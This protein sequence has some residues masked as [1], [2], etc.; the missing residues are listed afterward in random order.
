M[1]SIY[2]S[3]T[4]SPPSLGGTWELI[5]DGYFLMSTTGVSGE[6]GGSESHSHQTADHTLT[7]YEMPS[8]NHTF[9]GPN[10]I[11]G[12]PDGQKDSDGSSTSSGY[13]YWRGMPLTDYKST[14]SDSQPG[15]LNTGNNA[16][17]NHGDTWPT[18]HIPP[19]ITC[20][21]YKRTA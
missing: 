17:H 1:G 15:I 21:M 13:R 8:H 10:N 11:N 6:T 14:S 12:N 16:P 2:L 5:Y 4:K 20:F 3:L 7:I 18:K 19:Y 9:R